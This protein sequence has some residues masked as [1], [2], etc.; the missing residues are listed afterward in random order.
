MSPEFSTG[1]PPI[2]YDGPVIR[3]KQ[4]GALKMSGPKITKKL[5]KAI[6]AISMLPKPRRSYSGFLIDDKPPKKV[7]PKVD[8]EADK[9]ADD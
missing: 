1:H 4:L 2:P 3:D 6:D 9:D 8:T 5:A 7:K